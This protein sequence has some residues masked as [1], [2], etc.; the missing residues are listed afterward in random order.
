MAPLPSVSLTSSL[1]GKAALVTGAGSG[2]G[3][4]IAVALAAQGA[5]VALADLR[6]DGI[7]DV[8]EEIRAAGGVAVALTGDV[9]SREDARA[10]VDD[11]RQQ[12]GRLD[13]LVNN[14]G[15]QYVSPVHEFPEDRWDQLLGIMLT[16]PFLTTRYALPGMLEAGWGRIINV[17][18]I[19]SMVASRFKA[20]YNSA[21]FGLLG[22]TKTV[23]LETAGTG[24]TV[25]CLCPSYV[26]TPL[27][28]QQIPLLATKHGIPE[29]EVI[30]TVILP[31]C[32]LG[33][34]LEP[35]EVAQTTLYLCS[36]AAA[37]MTGAALT[38]DG[39]WTAQ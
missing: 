2:I 3:K 17:G 23:A 20:A 7:A 34:L 30:R 6:P 4:A 32:P 39:G 14:A 21:K 28:E 11:T 1:S 13:I 12:F 8:Q 38:L 22:L 26:R 24:V 36:D 31:N 27:I 33:R 15:L 25:N 29:A 5:A 18:S 37:G 10:W 19:H 9:S 35:E 16:G